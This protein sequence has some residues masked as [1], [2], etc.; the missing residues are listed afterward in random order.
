MKALRTQFDDMRLS[1]AVATPTCS[2]C[3]CCCCCL[4]TSIASSS[5]LAQRIAKEGERH[6]VFNRHVLT[7]L[8]TLFVP[9]VGVLVYFGFWTIN[10]LFSTC[11][12]HNYSGLYRR[13][14]T[15]EV[16]TNPGSAAI[17]PLLVIVPFLVLFYLYAR[18]RI[19][20]PLKR[21]LLV[22]AIIAIAFT[23]EFF[24]GAFLILTGVGGLAYLIMIPIIVGWISVWYYKHLGKEVDDDLDVP[25][26]PSASTNNIN[27]PYNG[28]SNQSSQ[29]NTTLTG[30][31]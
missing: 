30:S 15:Y 9:I 2:S 23:A 12:T 7:I 11:T 21:A 4:A 8:A 31:E 3:C 6:D 25:K 20:N 10:T 16:C 18:V 1:N 19:E 22:T 28:Q 14:A 13:G 27:E 29:S 17:L 26:P 24:G 5:L